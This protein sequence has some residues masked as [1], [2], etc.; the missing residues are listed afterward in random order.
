MGS[1]PLGLGLLI[2][3]CSYASRVMPR[4]EVFLEGGL[5][6][7]KELWCGLSA[8]VCVLCVCVCVQ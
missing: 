3:A 6:F 2:L 7:V 4:E 5:W 8:L 1:G